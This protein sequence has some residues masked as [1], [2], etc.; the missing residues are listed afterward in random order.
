M[1][2]DEHVAM[3]RKGVDAWNEWR[4]E[5]PLNIPDL[6]GTNLSGTNLRATVLEVARRSAGLQAGAG[7]PPPTAATA[8][9]PPVHRSVG[10]ASARSRT[11]R[12]RG[13]FGQLS[14]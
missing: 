10:F 9:T 4:F 13:A 2:N 11:E 7:A 6:S 1:A 5:K 3:L 12:G 14:T 8:L